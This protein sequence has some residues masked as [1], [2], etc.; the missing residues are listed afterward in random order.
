MAYADF[1]LSRLTKKFNLTLDT[2]AD[3]YAHI[4]AVTPDPTFLSRLQRDMEMALKVSTER[5]RSEFIIA[6]ILAEV[7]YMAHNEIALFSGVEFTVDALQ[8]LS[9]FCDYIVTRSRQQ[10]FVEAPVL[11]LAEAKNEEIKRG[12]AQC[13][14]E[15]IAA[16][17]FNAREGSDVEKI[18]GAV[19]IG[20]QWKFLELEGAV[21]RIDLTDYYIEHLDKI[22]GILLYMATG[23]TASSAAP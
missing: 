9:G 5:S 3:L 8:D 19:R 17:L 13:F 4:P 12:Y 10:L 18:Y 16:Q 15:M 11:M 6:P 23:R 22:M 2:N 7:R 20:N 21:A 14:A 1:T